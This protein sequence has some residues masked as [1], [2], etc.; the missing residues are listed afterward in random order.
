MVQT[1]AG[2]LRVLKHLP[3]PG[4]AYYATLI[5]QIVNVSYGTTYYVTVDVCI[6]RGLETS[7]FAS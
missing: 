7:R 3:R 1:E 5:L 6:S 2:I 4:N